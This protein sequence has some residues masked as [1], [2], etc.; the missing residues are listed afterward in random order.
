MRIVQ[1]ELAGKEF[2]ATWKEGRH[3]LDHQTVASRLQKRGKI[4]YHIDVTAAL[5]KT[6]RND[7][8]FSLL[9]LGGI[10]DSIGN[11]WNLNDSTF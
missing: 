10:Q 1:S 2:T 9:V 6:E 11:V 7:L 8:I 3:N 5:Q 4:V